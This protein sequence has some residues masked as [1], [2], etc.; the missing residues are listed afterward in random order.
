M[1]TA[2]A[3]S[4]VH[5]RPDALQTLLGAYEAGHL[6]ARGHHR[7]LR[8]ARTVA[9]LEDEPTVERRHVLVALALRGHDGAERMAA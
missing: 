8:V 7:T 5:A 6:S 9:D 1:D 4:H 3:A 2:L